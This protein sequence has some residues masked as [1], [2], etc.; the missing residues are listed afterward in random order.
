MLKI[1]GD[2]KDLNKQEND[3]Y[4]IPIKDLLAMKEMEYSKDRKT[5]LLYKGKY[6]G[7][8]F[9]VMNLGTHPTAYVNIPKR[10][11]LYGKHYDIIPI[12]CHWGLTYSSESLEVEE[13]VFEKGWFIGWDYSHYRD[14]MGY[15][16]GDERVELNYKKWTTLEIV[17][18]CFE[19]INQLDDKGN[20]NK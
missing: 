5:E 6:K 1:K 12:E 17:K 19:V 4:V 7:Y 8:E 13:D 14:Y 2:L 18:E 15:Y 9:Y 11:K 16:I 20:I 10:H 3:L